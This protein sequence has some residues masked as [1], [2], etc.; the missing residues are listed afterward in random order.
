MG[1]IINQNN[2]I[3][4]FNYLDNI[5]ADK[6]II[7]NQHVKSFIES[8][9]KKN[10][11]NKVRCE[12]KYDDGSFILCFY[13]DVNNNLSDENYIYFGF[14]DVNDDNMHLIIS[15]IQKRSLDDIIDNPYENH[16][17]DFVGKPLYVSISRENIKK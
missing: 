8:Q 14:T 5:G 7:N 15:K 16:N 10:S 3:N 12:E 2:D 1:T 17:Y 13:K 9:L 4:I 6:T 11:H